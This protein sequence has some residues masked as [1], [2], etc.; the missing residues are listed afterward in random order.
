MKPMLAETY[1]NETDPT[2]WLVSEKHDGIRAIWTGRELL[3]REGNRLNAPASFRAQLP[4]GEALDGELVMGR[5]TLQ[6]TVRTV[7]RIGGDWSGVRFMVW[8]CMTHPKLPFSE[9]NTKAKAFCSG[10][11]VH[12]SQEI[13]KSPY[14]LAQMLTE[15]VHGGGEGVVLRRANSQYVGNRSMAMLKLK[16]IE[17][18][19]GEMGG[20]TE[21]VGALIVKWEGKSI[22]LA[23]GLTQKL[24]SNPPSIGSKI[25]F[26]F[27]G[28]TDSGQPRG[29]T[30]VAVRNYE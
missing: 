24:R 12:V 4:A 22:K 23:A 10:S 28:K 27:Q 5:G 2:G 16:S 9:R 19:E 13:C 11:L 7:K 3:T 21:N 20:A 6:A 17:S 1:T 29:A 18:A 8:D 25:T 26:N 15:V 30:F 14:H